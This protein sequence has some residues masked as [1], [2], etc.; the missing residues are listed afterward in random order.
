MG[1]DGTKKDYFV[2]VPANDGDLYFTA[3]TYYQEMIPSECI[4][5][6]SVPELFI[7]LYK[8]GQASRIAYQWYDDQFSRYILVSSS[9]YSAGDVFKF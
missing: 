8:Q 9:T 5:S 6:G 4:N 2:T 3:E 1:D 7:D